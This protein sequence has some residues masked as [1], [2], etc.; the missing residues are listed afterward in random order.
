MVFA[1]LFFVFVFLMLNLLSQVILPKPQWK[2][3]AML[4]FSLIFYTWTG[5][6]CTLL[7]LLM[8]YICKVGA[9]CIEEAGD[10]GKSKKFPLTITIFLCLAILG[11]FKYAGFAVSTAAFVTGENFNVPEIALP[12]GISFYTFQLISYVVDVYRSEIAAQRTYWRLLLY[13]C[14][15]HQCIAG[16]IVRYK[17]VKK[18][19]DERNINVHDVGEGVRRF[20][21]GLMKKAVIANSC[22][23]IAD[24]LLDVGAEALAETS[25][26]GIFLGLFALYLRNYFDFSGYSDMAVGMGL[27]CGIHY[28]E[29]FNYPYISQS[30]SELWRRWHI[31]LCTFFRDYLYF[32]LGGSRC[33]VLKQL[34]NLFVV[35]FFTGL[36]HGAGWNYVLWGLYWCVMLVIQKFVVKDDL[37]WLPAPIK[38]F[39]ITMISIFGLTLFQFA[40]LGLAVIAFKG[41]FMMNGNSLTDFGTALIFKNN[42]FLLIFGMLAAT[43]IFKMMRESLQ[44]MSYTSTAALIVYAACEV[45]IPLILFVLA[46]NALA[47][48]SYNPFIYFQF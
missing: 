27:I 44:K 13:A 11:V 42:I 4:I 47:G 17:D 5:I 16:P 14:L 35:W 6:R 40:D 38:V 31:S 23:L 26:A 37:S 7:M 22:S 28:K 10:K 8:V 39:D 24:R 32:P 2:N 33:S 3:I 29:N 9:V 34:R 36:W 48:D 25:A 41:L 30:V 21:T 18:D 19:L 45:L 12:V 1:S 46:V 43:P 15:F 20:C